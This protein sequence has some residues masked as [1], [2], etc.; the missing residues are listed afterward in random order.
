MVEEWASASSVLRDKAR[1]TLDMLSHFTTPD[2]PARANGKVA[3]NDAAAQASIVNDRPTEDSE[4]GGWASLTEQEDD[5]ENE[6]RD[7]AHSAA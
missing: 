5:S 2:S 1:R 3:A 4:E 6:D 7:K